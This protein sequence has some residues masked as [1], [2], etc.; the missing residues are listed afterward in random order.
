M[1]L[2]LNNGTQMLRRSNREDRIRRRNLREIARRANGC[3]EIHARQKHAIDVTG[4]DIFDDFR[5]A[6]PERHVR[7][8]VRK[9]LRERCSPRASA[10]D[11]D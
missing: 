10:D 3:V 1:L 4:I 11:A 7:I 8:V 2:A 5:L 9:R 6:R